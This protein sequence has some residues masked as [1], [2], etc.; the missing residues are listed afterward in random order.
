V[1]LS[2]LLGAVLLSAPAMWTDRQGPGPAEPVTL[3]ELVSWF[4]AQQQL[5]L[6]IAPPAASPFLQHGYPKALPF[7]PADLTIHTPEDDTNSSYDVYYSTC[8]LVTNLVGSVLFTNLNWQ[9]LMRSPTN[10]IAQTNVYAR[11]LREDRGLFILIDATN[12][13]ELIVESNTT[14]QAMAELLMPPWVTV[15]NADYTGAAVARGTFTYGNC[16]GLPIDSGVILSSGPITNA[17]GPNNDGGWTAFFDGSADLEYPGNT[18]L[19]NLVGGTNSFDAAVLAFDIISTNSAIVQFQYVFAS[20]EYPEYSGKGFNDLMAIFV[21]TNHVGMQWVIGPTNNIALIPCTSNEI[22]AVN[23]I[24]GGFTDP[25]YAP[26]NAQYYIDNHDP[27]SASSAAPHAAGESAFNIQYDGMTVLL[28]TQLFVTAN[29][30]THI[31]IGI[32]DYSEPS[33]DSAV[34]LRA[35]SQSP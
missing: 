21:S 17:F 27:V 19:D 20:E 7:E 26:A 35:W 34:F 28:T 11:Y 10:I 12:N 4:R 14:A 22:V 9:F 25:Y 16:C 5:V 30:A 23:K 31:E 15:T 33:F 1:L 3:P 32:E 13:C 8:E 18:N 29:V 6:P 24:G 2:V